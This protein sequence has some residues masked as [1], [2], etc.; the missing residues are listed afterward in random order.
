MK[1]IIFFLA[2]CL[3]LFAAGCKTD[4]PTTAVKPKILDSIEI[5]TDTASIDIT[6]TCLDEWYVRNNYSKFLIQDSIEYLN[7]LTLSKDNYADH[8][9]DTFKFPEIDFN[10]YSLVGQYFG[11][12]DVLGEQIVRQ[13]YKYNYENKYVFKVTLYDRNGGSWYWAKLICLLVPK[14][15]SG[16]K[17][18]YDSVYVKIN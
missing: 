12:R 8:F 17:F 11:L 4:T 10:R 7:F 13:L 14:I 15:P 6:W 16:W 2:F 1:N 5:V 18:E 3:V 9:C